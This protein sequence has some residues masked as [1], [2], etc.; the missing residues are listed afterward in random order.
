MRGLIGLLE[1]TITVLDRLRMPVIARVQGAV[2]GA[3]MSLMLTGDVVIAADDTKLAFAYGSIG[4]TP[5][6]GLSWALP[7]AVGHLRAMRIALLGEAIEAEEALELGLVTKVV[8]RDELDAAT[9]KVAGRLAAGP[10][11]AYARTRELLRTRGATR[12][13]SSSRSSARASSPRRGRRTSARASLP[14][15]SAAAR[16]PRCAT[17]RRRGRAPCRCTGASAR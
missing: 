15:S 11:Q 1:E 2:A 17:S 8:P 6:G 13:P 12:W 7:R 4:T 14:S 3:G 10:T 16:V 5:D 9:A